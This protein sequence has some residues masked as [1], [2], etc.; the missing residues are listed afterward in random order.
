MIRRL[1]WVS[2][3]VGLGATSAIVASR[4]TRK[5]VHKAAPQTIAREARGGL[6]DLIKLV[7]SS[8]EEGRRAADARERELRGRYGLDEARS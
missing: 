4:W 1:F 6:H 7:N 3:G 8:A 5:Q 2:F